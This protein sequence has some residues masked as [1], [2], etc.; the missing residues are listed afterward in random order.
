MASFNSAVTTDQGIT[1][2]ADLLAGQQ[3]VF[4]KLVTGSGVYTG[5]DV[6]RTKLQKVT[7]LRDQRQE[8]EISSITKTTDTCVLLKTLIS[9]KDLTTGYRMT[10][11]GVYAKKQGD[12]GDGI[13]YSVAVAKE[14]DYFPCYNGFAAVEIVEEYYITVSD[15]TEVLLQAGSGASVLIEDFHKL[16]IEIA[17]IENRIDN[18]DEQTVKKSDILKTIEEVQA[19]TDDENVVSAIVVDGMIDTLNAMT[20]NGTIKGIEVRGDGVYITYVPSDGADTVSKKLGRPTIT[21]TGG[22]ILGTDGTIDVGKGHYAAY[23]VGLTGKYG[24]SVGVGDYGNYEF[25]AT[26]N[27]TTGLITWHSDVH[28]FGGYAY[29]VVID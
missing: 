1:L 29:I 5:E 21:T 13:L 19:N 25:S 9:N 23:I 10:E 27:S 15:T 8:F 6:E 17:E 4:T 18:L 22:R 12:E 24:N 28:N 26:Y 14:A 2:V 16:K 11:I 3:I 20:D 7:E